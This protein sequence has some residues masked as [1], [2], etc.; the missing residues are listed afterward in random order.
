MEYLTKTG[1]FKSVYFD[2]DT[3]NINASHVLGICEEIKR[4]RLVVPWAAMARADLMDETVLTA[5][6][7]AGLHSVKYGVE[8]ADQGFLDEVDKHM[9][10]AKAERM[11]RLTKTLG[12]KVHLS[13]VFGM[14]GETQESIHRTIDYA[15]S[16]EPD[17]VQF[18]ILTPYP[19]TAYYRRLQSQGD[20]VSQNW[21]DYNGASKSVIKTAT[22]T[23]GDLEKARQEAL[24]AW[25]KYRRSKKTIMTMPFDKELRLAFRNNIKNNGA[26]RTLIKTARYIAGI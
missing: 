6:R 14:P 23:P 16:L 4:R 7:Q 26:A 18:S 11:I 3:F 8:S 12:I 20:I 22:L 13:F 1:T 19:G 2:D 10:L 5:M 21:S 17:T 9:D 15:M 24:A 25:R